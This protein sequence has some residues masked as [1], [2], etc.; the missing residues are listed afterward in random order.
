MYIIAICNAA[1]NFVKMIDQN[2]QF[3]ELK[4]CNTNLYLESTG[5]QYFL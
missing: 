3:L 5:T 4:L 1:S 2:K